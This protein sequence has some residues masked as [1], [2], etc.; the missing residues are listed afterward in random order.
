MLA[1]IALVI[2]AP[3]FYKRWRKND[4]MRDDDP[5]AATP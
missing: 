4:A 2:F 5:T 3:Q 1:V